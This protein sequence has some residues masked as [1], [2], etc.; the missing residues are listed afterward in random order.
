MNIL[1]VSQEMRETMISFEKRG[2]PSARLRSGGNRRAERNSSLRERGKPWLKEQMARSAQQ[3]EG[4]WKPVRERGEL[5]SVRL[6]HRP[7]HDY[8]HYGA[9]LMVGEGF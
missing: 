8:G 5:A 4:Y 7:H 6:K 1:E 3:W 2:A 9:L